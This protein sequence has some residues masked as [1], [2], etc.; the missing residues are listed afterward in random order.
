M[1][2]GRFYW[3]VPNEYISKINNILKSD[4]IPQHIKYFEKA[5]PDGVFIVK[6]DECFT[7]SSICDEKW[8]KKNKFKFKGDIS[9]KY[10]RRKKLEKLSTLWKTELISG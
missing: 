8:L 7:H 5:N 2:K 3:F 1:K 6:I 9:L 10:E 4:F